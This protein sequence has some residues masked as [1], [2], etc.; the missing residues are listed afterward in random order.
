MQRNL[1]KVSAALVEVERFA[2]ARRSPTL[3]LA[4]LARAMPQGSALTTLRMETAADTASVFLT[5]LAPRA[6]PV[7]GAI[8]RLPGVASA[9]IVGPV[10]REV[11]VAGGAAGPSAVERATL[12]RMTVRFRLVATKPADGDT[13]EAAP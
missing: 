9:Q 5:L 4:G 8:E 6:A 11:V 10:T 2:G 7:L 13:S 1:A 12:E 3:L